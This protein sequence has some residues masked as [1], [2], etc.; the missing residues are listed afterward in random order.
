MRE[1]APWRTSK[2]FQIEP[3]VQKK[4]TREDAPCC[5]VITF[6]CKIIYA[7]SSLLEF[8]KIQENEIIDQNFIGF[9]DGLGL[10]IPI[11]DDISL[12]QNES[13]PVIIKKIKNSRNASKC[14]TTAFLFYNLSHYKYMG[15]P[16]G[17]FVEGPRYMGLSDYKLQLDSLLQSA[18]KPQELELIQPITEE[19]YNALSKRN[20][21]FDAKNRSVFTRLLNKIKHNYDGD[22][23]AVLLR[24]LSDYSQFFKLVGS[25]SSINESV[26]KPD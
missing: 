5:M 9:H 4:V 6:D 19:I 13:H 25:Q 1:P 11:T 2:E 7:N 16:M 10:D 24:I 17:I 8:Y 15:A 26:S 21:Q 14:P 12:I 23:Q 22:I 20:T 3:E 18:L